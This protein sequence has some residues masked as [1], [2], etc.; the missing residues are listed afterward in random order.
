MKRIFY[1]QLT[2]DVSDELAEQFAKWVEEVA[3]RAYRM[4]SDY[5]NRPSLWKQRDQ[6]FYSIPGYIND[7]NEPSLLSLL[8]GRGHDLAIAPI[9]RSLPDAPGTL[10]ATLEFKAWNEPDPQ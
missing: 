6:G 1:G 4:N 10:E 5:M 9:S 8:I 7:S 3:N 2:I